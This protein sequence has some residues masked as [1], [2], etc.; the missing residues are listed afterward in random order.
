MPSDHPQR[1]NPYA[2]TPRPASHEPDWARLADQPEP[3]PADTRVSKLAIVSLITSFTCLLSPLAVLLSLI[4]LV[5]IQTSAG[6]L[7]G[8]LLAIPA[9][10]IGLLLSGLIAFVVVGAVGIIGQARA[11]AATPAAI[12]DRR[13]ADADD[14][15]LPAVAASITQDQWNDFADRVT[16]KLGQHRPDAPSNTRQYLDSTNQ[17]N[18]LNQRL[19]KATPPGEGV[20]VPIWFPS[21]FENATP[22]FAVLIPDAGA[23]FSEL[24]F[25]RSGATGQASNFVFITPDGEAIWLLQPPQSLTTPPTPAPDQAPAP[26][27]TPA[28]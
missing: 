23:F 22:A 18:S 8:R 10:V 17:I 28:P 11:L 12:A 27:P 20:L 21:A 25:G 7:Q 14:F 19:A 15:L 3:A 9:L 2:P 5:R 26:A 6:K 4:S 1:P 13:F 24:V 16:A